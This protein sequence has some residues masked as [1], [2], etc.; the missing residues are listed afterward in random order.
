MKTLKIKAIPSTPAEASQV[1][2]LLNSHDIEWQLVG[3]NNWP[4]GYPYTPQAEFRIAHTPDS[5]LINYRATEQTVRATTSADNGPVWTDSCME[6]FLSPDPSANAYY[7]LECNCIG[8]LLLGVSG[9]TIEKTHAT[10]Q[11]L[12][13]IKRWSSLG[14]MPFEEHSSESAWMVSLIV[15]FSSFW[16]HTMHPTMRANFYKC[17]DLLSKPHF[18]SWNP[19]EWEK[20]NFHLPQFFGQIKIEQ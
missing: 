15:P 7:N 8:T 18:L 9:D 16:L 11:I 10:P 1:D 20:P 19:I 12:G 17:G 13:G 3:C 2:A 6:F 4:A 14:N 5:F